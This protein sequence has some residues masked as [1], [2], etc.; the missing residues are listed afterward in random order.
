MKGTIRDIVFEEQS[1]PRAF[2]PPA[3]SEVDV[4]DS[5]LQST[6]SISPLPRVLSPPE[7][8]C[9]VSLVQMPRISN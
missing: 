8:T 1:S 5:A 2:G 4:C 7:G 3:R 9:G 6:A